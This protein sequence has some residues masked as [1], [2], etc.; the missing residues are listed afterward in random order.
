MERNFSPL[1][2]KFFGVERKDELKIVSLRLGAG[3]GNVWS[4]D[5]GQW[6]S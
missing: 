1:I 5:A 2:S 3:L 6:K 4:R